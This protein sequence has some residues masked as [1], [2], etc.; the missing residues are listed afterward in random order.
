MSIFWKVFIY[1]RWM[2]SSFNKRGT[3][4][5]ECVPNFT[6]A[7]LTGREFT[8]S[9]SFPKKAVVLW[10]TNLCSSCEGRIPILQKAYEGNKDSLEIIAISTLGNDMET[11]ERILKTHKIEF[12]LLIDPEDWVGKVLGFEHAPGAC[13][14]YNLLILDQ[15][16]R[17]SLKHHLSAIKDAD[18]LAALKRVG[19]NN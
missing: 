13:P 3:G 18:F 11:P 6:L 2:L 7:D 9:D 12:P 5:G 8:L 16:G 19:A 14:L 17:I 4:V 10:L 1:A 15:T